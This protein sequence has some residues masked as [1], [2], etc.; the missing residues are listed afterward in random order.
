MKIY[1]TKL[2]TNQL[3]RILTHIA[4]DKI[5]ASEKFYEDLDTQIENLVDFP[6]KYRPS[7]YSDDENVRDMTFKGYTIQYKVYTNK[8]TILKIFNRNKP[9]K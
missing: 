8:I 5:S 4:K 6:F 3:L 9:Q 1:R 7:F 2:Y